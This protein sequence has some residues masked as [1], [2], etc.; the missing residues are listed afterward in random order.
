MSHAMRVLLTL[1]VGLA[2]AGCGGNAAPTFGTGPPLSH[3]VYQSEMAIIMRET[4]DSDLPPTSGDDAS[5]LEAQYHGVL[6]Q[7]L[8]DAAR[9]LRTLT[10]PAADRD[11]HEQL[12]R[13]LEQG[14]D[15]LMGVDLSTD[16]ETW[17]TEVFAALY[18]LGIAEEALES[19]G[20]FLG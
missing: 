6:P 1:A 18:E 11:V 12:V 13:A 3:D 15:E 4:A 8:R 2:L 17:G 16:V 14:A 10:P 5:D 7:K 20:Y 9:A 19:R